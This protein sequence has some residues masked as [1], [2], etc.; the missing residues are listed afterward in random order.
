MEYED[1]GDKGQRHGVKC[2][3]LLERG[4]E[5]FLFDRDSDAA[6]S[7]CYRFQPIPSSLVYNHDKPRKE[8]GVPGEFEQKS[9]RN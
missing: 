1:D 2:F 7:F 6:P 9:Y 3:L 8:K 5:A 4:P